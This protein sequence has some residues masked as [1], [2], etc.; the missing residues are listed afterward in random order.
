MDTAG[1]IP[2]IIDV[3]PAA[4]ATVSYPSG[5]QVE[6]G[7]ELTPTQVKDQP[8]VT[9]EADAGSLY[10]LLLVDPDAPSRAD[11][12]LREILHWAVINI[13]GNKVADGQ[14]L[15]EYVG[16]APADGTGLHRYVF[17]V[18]KQ[19]DKITTDKFI[20]KTTREGRVSVKARD[21]IAKYSFGGPVAG[22]F[23]QA[24]YDDYVPTLRAQV[25]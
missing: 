5:A 18:F 9:W 22:N 14:V 13:P 2:D 8:T 23:F 1:I 10:T 19:N 24:Q 12:K 16:A 17:L 4:K 21:Y 20:S 6:L 11:P 3:K 15:A 25:Q 7:K